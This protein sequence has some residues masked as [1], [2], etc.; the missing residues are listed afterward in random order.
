MSD[1]LTG[2]FEKVVDYNFTASVELDFDRIADNKLDRN[3]MLQDFY[4]PFHE[5]IEKSGDI[6][7][8][9]VSQAREIGVDPKSGG[10]IIARFGRFGPM[11]QLGEATDEEKPRFA[12][13]P[14]GARLET[15]TLEQA[16]EMFKLP[17][18]VGTTL[19]GKEIK[20]N[21][22][23]FG[24]YVQVEKEFFSIKGL[25]PLTVTELE[26]REVISVISE[27]RKPIK[28]FPSGVVILN[29]PYGPY[30]KK[31]KTN[32][33][34]P[35]DVDPGTITEEQAIDMI[36]NAPKKSAKGRFA[37]KGNAK[38]TTTKRKSTKKKS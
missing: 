2:H 37:R 14:K 20:A 23:R 30:I 16:L 33:R 1:F 38:K 4:T 29:G 5:L 32:A 17:R 21:I 13:L 35:K 9:T 11:L 12:P 27:K 24:P 6:D 36:A 10:M 19:Q 18:V 22:G 7:R 34:I 26:A 3:K 15:V 25:D 31:D 28:E 8:S